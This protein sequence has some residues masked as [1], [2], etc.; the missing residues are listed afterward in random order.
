MAIL[1]CNVVIRSVNEDTTAVEALDPGFMAQLAG[2]DA[3]DAVAKDAGSR[4]KAMLEAIAED[5]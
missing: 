2:D 1:P 5:N 3:L 4:L